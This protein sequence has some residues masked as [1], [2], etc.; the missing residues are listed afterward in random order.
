VRP[1]SARLARAHAAFLRR[2]RREAREKTTETSRRRKNGAETLGASRRDGDS[3]S[4]SDSEWVETD[5]EAQ[6]GSASEGEA[7]EARGLAE[8]MGMMGLAA[9]PNTRARRA[10][11]A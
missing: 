6:Q 11:V 2:A 3:D 9:S 8:G 7:D 1:Y 10:R 4:D 5:G